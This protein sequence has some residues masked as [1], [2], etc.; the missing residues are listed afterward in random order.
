MPATPTRDSFVYIGTFTRRNDGPTGS[1]G[2]YV[3]RLNADTG[4]ITA[5]DVAAEVDNPAF[6][7]LSPDRRFLYAVSEVSVPGTSGPPTGYVYAFAVDGGTGRLTLLNRA[8]SGGAGPCH[9]EA[10]PSGAM[11]AVANYGAGSVAALPI[12]A[13]GSLG[14]AISILRHEGRGP[15]PERQREPHAHCINFSP[16]GRFAF[17]ADLGVD[18]VFIYAVDPAERALR[19]H[20]I[21]SVNIAAGAGPRHFAMHPR[22]SHA[23]VINE[24]GNSITAFEYD[25]AGSFRQIQTISTLP[26]GFA[27]PSTTAEI[28]VHPTGK[29]VYGSNRGHDTIAVYRVEIDG[30]LALVEHASTGGQSPRCF[31]I[32]PSGRWLIAANQNSDNLAAFRIDLKSGGLTPHGP[33]ISVHRPCCVTF[34][35]KP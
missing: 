26:D 1:R 22:G 35:Q 17:A 20:S 12:H 33:A 25:G 5:L 29:F 8:S 6:L 2:I 10:S 34:A 23:Y 32:D 16:D 11:L 13:D 7:A 4:E 3:G 14:E 31:G 28:V 24:L 21:A 27:A 9:L 30:R 19:P 18:R 15:H